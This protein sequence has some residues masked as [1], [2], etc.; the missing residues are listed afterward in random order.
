MENKIHLI[1]KKNKLL[2]KVIVHSYSLMTQIIHIQWLHE[3][4]YE[5]WIWIWKLTPQWGLFSVDIMEAQENHIFR[6]SDD[7]QVSGLFDLHVTLS[8]T[9]AWPWVCIVWLRVDVLLVIL[10]IYILAFFRISSL[11]LTHSFH[12]FF[13][14]PFFFTHS[15]WW[16]SYLWKYTF[17]LVHFTQYLFFFTIPCSIY[18]QLVRIIALPHKTRKYLYYIMNYIY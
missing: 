17:N 8:M 4:E 3:Y 9:F 14:W 1:I 5:I 7:K 15:F 6:L 10:I 13:S 16:N 2:I 18:F 11:S 12:S